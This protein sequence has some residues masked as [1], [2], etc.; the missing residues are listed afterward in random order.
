MIRIEEI[1]TVSAL[2]RY[3]KEWNYI[4]GCASPLD[5]FHTYDW[6][7]TWLKNFWQDRPLCFLLV[8]E[9]NRP[10]AIAPLLDDR[11]GD[12]WCRGSL[13][14]PI[15]GEAKRTSIILFNGVE[16]ILESVFTFLKKTRGRV[17]LTLRNARKDSPLVFS[18]PKI[19]K[20]YHLSTCISQRS[21]SPILRLNGTWSDYL[22]SKSRHFCK[23]LDR[24]SRLIER[25]GKADWYVVTNT[26][27]V[28]SAIEN[29]LAIEENS[30]KH[31]EGR[32]IAARPLLTK[33]YKEF[34]V[35]CAEK[36][37]LRMHFLSLND[38]PIAYIYGLVFNNE[39]FALKTSYNEKYRHLSPGTVLFGYAIR[40]G[41][42]K[43]LST[44]DFLG[45][46][47]RWKNQFASD[48]R[49]HVDLCIFSDHDLK[50][51]RCKFY[52]QDFKPFVRKRLPFV[53]EARRKIKLMREKPQA[54]TA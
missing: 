12:L 6:V 29:F 50:C 7:Y 41:F 30:W 21:S 33:F 24:K 4:L 23:E 37:W 39:Y 11:K 15:N 44:F 35:R 43:K 27:Q 3:E 45:G 8:R 1:R 13:V 9:Q 53:L 46:E 42:E 51:R 34:A 38:I 22:N 26:N 36:G 20:K 25:H 31:K 40:D 16:K 2:E 10:F 5:F 48:L 17:R 32:S 54:G 18:M 14:T 19:A 28:E 52:N 49:Q 47:D